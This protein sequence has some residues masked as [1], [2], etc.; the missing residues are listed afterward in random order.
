[1]CDDVCP[2]CLENNNQYSYELEPCK[3]KFH[4]KCIIKSLRTNGPRCPMC[5]GHDNDY[6]SD[7]SDFE[8]NISQSEY[9]PVQLQVEEPNLTTL[10]FSN[11]IYDFAGNNVTEY[12]LSTNN[13]NIF[14]SP[15]TTSTNTVSLET[16]NMYN[17][18]S[19]ILGSQ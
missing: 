10:T 11:E 19:Q 6:R 2:I 1:M 12:V 17:N 5:R 13:D 4:S 14:L 16:I 7:N 18:E 3:H 8:L 15:T 9:N